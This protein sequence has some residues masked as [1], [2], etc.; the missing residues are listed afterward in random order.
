MKNGY[1]LFICSWRFLRQLESTSLYSAK[2][3]PKLLRSLKSL[4]R[5]VTSK[6]DGFKKMQFWNHQ[7]HACKMS[8]LHNMFFPKNRSQTSLGWAIM[9][10]GAG[11]CQRSSYYTWKPHQPLS[12]LLEFPVFF[13]SLHP[14]HAT[15]PPSGFSFPRFHLLTHRCAARVPPEMESNCASPG[16]SLAL[17]SGIIN[18]NHGG[19]HES[20]R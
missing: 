17:G 2:R 10:S 13:V 20:S 15:S 4:W 16:K 12:I 3:S 5:P 11:F 19:F 1:S 8:F 9:S 7:N 18:K 6:W 14:Q